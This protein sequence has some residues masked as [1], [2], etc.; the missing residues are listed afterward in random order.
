MEFPHS[1][2]AARA[3][4]AAGYCLVQQDKA[5]Q[6]L[7]EFQR[8]RQLFPGTPAAVDGVN[9][10]SIA[11]RLYLRAPAQPAFT[12]AKAIGPEKSEFRDV[13]GISFDP[14]GQVMLGHKGGVTIFKA[15]GTI[16]QTVT[17]LDATAFFLDE[18]DRVVVARNGSLVTAKADAIAYSG[19]GSDGQLRAVDE[20]A[21]ALP[22][23]RG[24]RIISNIKQKN[25]IRA[26][27]NGKYVAVFAQGQVTRMAQNWLGDI[28]MLDRSTKSINVADRE[29]KSLSKIPQKG[30]GYELDDPT[31]VAYDALGHLYVLDRG[32][33]GSILVF[34]PKNKLLSTLSVPASSPGALSRGE[35]LGVDPA[36]RLYVFDDRTRRIQVYQ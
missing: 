18:Q 3:S 25:V 7:Q 17:A 6:A 13:T 2:W 35:A 34:G 16:A 11:Y 12:F 26:L 22:N 32:R 27:P 31:D 14:T 36:G 19:P 21:A 23:S 24:E 8:A 28:A 15:D 10:N 29:G 4:L 30:A 5:P 9:Y 33:N 20:I 1:I